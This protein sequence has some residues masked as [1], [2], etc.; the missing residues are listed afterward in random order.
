LY[1]ANHNKV[2]DIHVTTEN[3]TSK[4]PVVD[5]AVDHRP[6]AAK[7]SNHANKATPGAKQVRF[8]PE[9]PE[10]ASR[11][12][13]ALPL[14]RPKKKVVFSPLAVH[15]EKSM[16]GGQSKPAGNSLFGGAP[17]TTTQSTPSLFTAP[18]NTGA[19]AAGGNL[20]GAQQ[21]TNASTP[22]L[23]GNTSN[24]ATAPS[25]NPGNSAPKS[26]FGGFG[27][28][29]PANN[30]TQQPATS[31][32]DLFGNGAAAST[33]RPAGGMFGGLGGATS[34]AAQQPASTGSMF[35][36][37]LGGASTAPAPSAGGSLF[38]AFG[39]TTNNNNNTQQSAFGTSN[40]G[41]D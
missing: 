23:F 2:Q 30:T 29:A 40:L 22:S 12:E 3:M 33:A 26:M 1:N 10:R 21:P 24:S 7:M 14:V 8:A 20:F 6:S 25:T 37:A 19:P 9:T 11:L 34:N 15:L 18:S 27:G 41:K 28:A 35:G 32:T 13:A 16:F 36:G 17:T 39:A 31:S 5:T 4:S 38:G